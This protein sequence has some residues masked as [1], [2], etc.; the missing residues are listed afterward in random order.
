MASARRGW[1]ALARRRLSSALFGGALAILLAG[2]SLA[3]DAGVSGI[4]L[5]PANINGVNGTVRD[6]SGV[7]NASKVAPL[8]EPSIQPV[9][10]P[11][12]APLTSTRVGRVGVVQ[13][14]WSRL[15]PR[16]RHKLEEAAVKENDRLLKHGITSICRGC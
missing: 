2:A 7:G 4:P 1:L 8:P 5:G 12:A 3:Q 15:P 6:P 9:M 10:P 16:A 13:P 11:A 14:R